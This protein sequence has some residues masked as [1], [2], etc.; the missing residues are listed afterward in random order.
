LLDEHRLTLAVDEDVD[1]LHATPG[2][3]GVDVQAIAGVIET[4]VAVVGGLVS[5]V[6]EGAAQRGIGRRVVGR[7]RISAGIFH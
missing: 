1:A 2:V 5:M 4:F 3:G 6:P 7:L